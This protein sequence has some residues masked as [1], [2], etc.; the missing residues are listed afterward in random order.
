M[1]FSFFY[2]SLLSDWNHGNAHFL[3]GVVSDLLAR[4]HEVQVFE[5]AN[6]WSKA[7]M[8]QDHGLAPL[9]DF[10]KTYPQLTSQP[11]E[12]ES[13]DLE[14][15][16]YDSDV[17]VVHEWNEPWL[18][19]GLG[20]LR[21]KLQRGGN[22]EQSFTLLFHDT[23]HRAVSDPS[24]LHRFKL[25]YYDGVLAFGESLTEVY[26]RHGWHHDVWTW[27]EAADT[28]V[29]YP[30]Q[31]N[32]RYPSGDF[33]WVGNWADGERAADLEEFLFFPLREMQLHSYAFGVNYPREVLSQLAWEGVHYGG[34]IANFRVPELYANFKFTVHVPRNYYADRLPGIPTIRPF[35]AMA[36]G[37]PLICS[38]WDDAEGLFQAGEDY[39]VARDA[40]EMQQHMRAVLED[41]DLVK[42]MTSTALATIRARHTCSH[43]VDQLLSIITAIKQCP[44]QSSETIKSPK[45]VAA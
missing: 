20:E 13:L 14:Q 9:N 31:P 3:R 15:V 8:L 25:E 28:R 19:N 5:P 21:N 44:Q 38:P 22:S 45:E 7:N 17:V 12:R 6:A 18:V 10:H 27:H 37:V 2:H 33:V 40:T 35:E 16:A 1:K 36:C 23:H 34:W 4:G 42:D 41:R 43:R 30:R 32:S 26:R 29:F 24:W 11:Y 39:L